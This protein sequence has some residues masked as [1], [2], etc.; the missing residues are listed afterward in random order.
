MTNMSENLQ[1]WHKWQDTEE[2]KVA[3]GGS[4]SGVVLTN[5]LWRAFLAGRVDGASTGMQLKSLHAAEPPPSTVNPLEE[6]LA[7]AKQNYNHVR[8]LLEKAHEERDVAK[9]AETEA[10]DFSKLLIAQRDTLIKALAA[11]VEA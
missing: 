1:A 6:Q 9:V 7:N 2:F 11:V 10:D 8:A 3:A 4:V 5:R